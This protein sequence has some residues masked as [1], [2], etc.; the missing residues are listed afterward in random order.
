MHLST[1]EIRAVYQRHAP[2]YDLALRIYRLIG[3]RAETYRLRAIELLHLEPGD[4]VVD[5]G[6]GTGLS[7]PSLLEKVGSEGRLIGVDLTP[8]MLTVARERIQRFG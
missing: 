3:L 6:C 4:I 5:L 8:G 2:H 7:F 1:Q